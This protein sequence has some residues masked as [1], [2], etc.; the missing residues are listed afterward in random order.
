VGVTLG[1]TSQEQRGSSKISKQNSRT[2]TTSPWFQASCL[3]GCGPS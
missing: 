2:S 1:G 3:G